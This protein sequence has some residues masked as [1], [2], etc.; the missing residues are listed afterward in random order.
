MKSPMT[1]VA[2]RGEVDDANS[3]ALKYK[4]MRKY[5]E[6]TGGLSSDAQ[7]NMPALLGQ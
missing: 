1:S 3:L 4:Q 7:Y 6:Y 5:G 2:Q